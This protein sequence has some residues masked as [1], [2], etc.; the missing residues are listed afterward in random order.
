MPL[1][2]VV[3]W[4]IRRSVKAKSRPLIGIV[5]IILWI[6]GVI[7]AS[8]LGFKVAEKFSVESSTEKVETLAGFNGNKLYVDIDVYKRQHLFAI[9]T[10]R[11][12]PVQALS[13]IHIFSR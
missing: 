1:I 6:G 4:I 5:A 2:A 12:W 8:L 3:V 10:R 7:T 11:R 9:Y 13:L